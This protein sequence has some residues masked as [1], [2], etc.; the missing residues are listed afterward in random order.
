MAKTDLEDLGE[1]EDEFT[2]TTSKLRDLVKGLTGFDIMEDENTFKDIYEIILGIGKEW[3]NLSDIEQASLGEA[4]AGKRNANALYAVLNNIETL[5]QAYEYAEDSANS[6]QREQENYMKSIQYSIDVFKASVQDLW[7]TLLDNGTIKQFV[8]FG[9]SVIDWLN[10]VAKQLGPGGVKG[11]L[12][13]LVPVLGT[14]LKL[15]KTDGS[16]FSGISTGLEVLKDLFTG[17]TFANTITKITNEAK[18][19]GKEVSGLV[20]ILQKFSSVIGKASDPTKSAGIA[21]AEMATG[22]EAAATSGAA[23]TVSFTGLLPVLIAVGAL[24]TGALLWD[25]FTTT[26][27]EAEAE[28]DKVTGRIDNL[29]NQIEELEKIDYRTT[30]QEERLQNLQKELEAQ[31]AILQVEQRRVNLEKYGDKFSDYFD[32][33]NLRKQY[34]QEMNISKK[35]S[36][37]SLE[38]DYRGNSKDIEKLQKEISGYEQKV[39]DYRNKIANGDLVE[40][41]ALQ[42]IEQ[43]Q[44]KINKKT[45]K[46]NKLKS[47]QSDIEADIN[48]K[49]LE[50][51]ANIEEI[52]A[53][54]KDARENPLYHS[55]SEIDD[56]EERL[57]EQKRLLDRAQ[58]LQKSFTSKPVLEGVED[59]SK[60]IESAFKHVS[61]EGVE[62]RLIEIGKAGNLNK[63]AVEDV[64]AEYPK[65]INVLKDAGVDTE[66]QIDDIYAYIMNK[67]DPNRV[68]R[69]QLTTDIANNIKLPQF[70]SKYY[71]AEYY[72]EQFKK[73]LEE[74]FSKEQLDALVGLGINLNDFSTMDA[75]D[76]IEYI[77][78]LLKEAGPAEVDISPNMSISET[79]DSINQQLKPALDSLGDVYTQVLSGPNQLISG[80][81]GS[82]DLIEQVEKIKSQLDS[83]NGIE[84]IT[85]DY[86]PFEH[87]VEVLQDTSSTGKEVQDAFNGVATSITNA[88]IEGTESINTLIAALSDFGVTNAAVVAVGQVAQDT[89]KLKA[90]GLDLIA[91]VEQEKTA[92][93]ETR[94]AVEAESDA[95]IEAW[96]REVAGA[97]DATEAIALLKMQKI[98][99]NQN[100]LNEEASIN[101]LIRLAG[102]AGVATD[103]LQQLLALQADI[104][105]AGAR[106][107]AAVQSG[108]T[109]QINEATAALG[110]LNAR[111]KDLQN[112]VQTSITDALIASYTSPGTTSAAKGGGS[113]AGKSYVDGFNEELSKLKQQ[114]ENG[115]IDLKTYLAQYRALIEK[116][117]SDTEKYAEERAKALHDYLTELKGYYDSA[118]SGVITLF[119]YKISSIEK[120]RDAAVKAAEDEKKAALDAIQSQIDAYDDLIDEI[121]DTIKE[122]QKAID[123]L[124]KEKE[125][126][127]EANAER[128]RQINLQKSLYDLER[129][130]QQRTQ[131]IYKNG[132]MVYQTD[133][134]SIRNA[135]KAVDDAETDIKIAEI[136]KRI[137]R[138]NDEIDMLNE[139]KE[140]YQEAQEAL[141]KQYEETEKFYDDMIQGIKD[142]FQEM[143]DQ[144]EQAKE[145][146]QRLMELDKIASAWSD[147]GQIME[148]L[149]FTVNDVLND[150]PGA[151]E[152]FEQAYIATLS[153]LNNGNDQYLQGLADV[154]GKS[155][156][157]LKK[158]G[159]GVTQIS[160]DVKEPLSNIA[161]SVKDLGTNAS[162]A[163]S[164]VSNLGSAAGTLSTNA[165]DADTAIKGVNDGLSQIDGSALDPLVD[166]LNEVKNLIG[167]GESGEGLVGI[168]NGLNENVNLDGVIEQFTNLEAAVQSVVSALGGGGGGEN[169]PLS[170]NNGPMG[171]NPS[172]ASSGGSGLVSA[173]EAVKKATNTNIGGSG[174]GGTEDQGTETEG[175]GVASDGTVVGDFGAFKGAVDE[176]T[177]AIGTGESGDNAGSKG[178]ADLVSAITNLGAV[179]H[180]VLTGEGEG[181][182]KD[183]GGGVIQDWV[184]WN[185]ELAK[186]HTAVTGIKDALDNLPPEK[187]TTL[188]VHLVFDDGNY[189]GTATKNGGHGSFSLNLYKTIG[190]GTGESEDFISTLKGGLKGKARLEGTANFSGNWAYEGGKTLIA[191]IGPELVVFP[192]GHFETFDRPQMVNLPRGSVIF[193]HLQTAEILD[194]KNQIRSIAGK[195]NLNGTVNGLTPLSLADPEQYAQFMQLADALKSNTEDM[196]VDLSDLSTMARDI[197]RSITNTTYDNSNR[198]ANITFGDLN[199]T[200]TG[201]TSADVLSEVGDALQREFSGIAL[202][203]YQRAMAH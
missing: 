170:P 7:A 182:S 143:I 84:G 186:A 150:T 76:A 132:Q 42:K 175:G 106:L 185:A 189:T 64:L 135:K 140:A 161:D 86:V 50:Y 18:E 63:K 46:L 119:D 83:L 56:L 103:A 171:S 54:L 177:S 133:T 146:W 197:E 193:N 69:D 166:K 163:S 10:D 93:D 6:A 137:A 24:I 62:D 41:V 115:E 70:D 167:G 65:F 95:T 165:K 129:A 74:E 108:M 134:D 184:D 34:I 12:L 179:D 174:G 199:F 160:S 183:N 127:Q 92:T 57:G 23:L 90:A 169:T 158:M 81:L 142:G 100:A 58:D 178:G 159:E 196:R 138:I 8:D 13:S 98:L 173:I 111:A 121:D 71:T 109:S 79:V 126:I 123:A 68:E 187:E 14:I 80:S 66:N 94:A 117:F 52:E 3:K 113:S 102:M 73:R 4:L 145:K 28:I 49:A 33:D 37:L 1:E 27:K 87:L 96:A 59:Y 164:G 31:E 67:A 201:I 91:L 9:T 88:G 26:V 153:G 51:Q 144:L 35:G 131:F 195:S 5:E 32:K 29:K 55:Q 176:V 39:L 203:A 104:G 82:I 78:K 43:L 85:V 75:E 190:V 21:M 198:N 180:A 110:A 122:K 191:E 139:Q 181:A 19:S 47:E 192:D 16:S 130:Q 107:T 11:V 77:N 118:I 200:C 149:G 148:T 22:A 147:V 136:D 89:E 162:S 44:D 48:S 154:T 97:E 72:A 188:T 38:A 99:L 152:A 15:I 202:N 30:A 155:V 60:Q 168:L 116:Y 151:F 156:E 141:R 17:E 120:S 25:H 194:D 40:N 125:K 61:F 105:A 2:K 53:R 128:E 45:D 101:E 114:Y 36:A 124:E 112:Q 20:G 157:E 172:G